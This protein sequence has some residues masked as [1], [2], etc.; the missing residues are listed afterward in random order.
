MT[1]SNKERFE[2]AD[3]LLKTIKIKFDKDENN[4]SPFTAFVDHVTYRAFYYYV[5][6]HWEDYL[7]EKRRNENG[8]EI[9]LYG[10]WKI[11][12]LYSTVKNDEKIKILAFPCPG[13]YRDAE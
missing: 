4:H 6:E 5:N 8:V 2:K 10:D 12:S 11:F 13:N 3:E 1:T 9:V 7:G